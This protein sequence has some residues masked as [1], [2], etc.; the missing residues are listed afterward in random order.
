MSSVRSNP[1]HAEGLAHLTLQNEAAFIWDVE[2]NQPDIKFFGF[3]IGDNM[4]LKWFSLWIPV[5]GPYPIASDEF[6]QIGTF[7]VTNL[8]RPDMYFFP[9]FNYN[10]SCL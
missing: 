2:F 7:K 4:F 1:L 8:L 10:V 5:L 9:E 6:V 3:I